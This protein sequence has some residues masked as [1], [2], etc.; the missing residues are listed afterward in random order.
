[1]IEIIRELPPS[2]LV[3]LVVGLAFILKMIGTGIAWAFSEVWANRK[4]QMERHD[5]ALSSN[6]MAI[7][8]LQVQIEQLMELLGSIPKMKEDISYAHSKIREIQNGQDSKR[9]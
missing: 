2:A 5:I 6:T 9:T 3:I 4:A 7:I 1:M 8:K